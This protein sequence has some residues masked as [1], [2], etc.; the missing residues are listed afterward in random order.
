MH[1]LTR[2]L[3]STSS[4]QH[5]LLR[6][7]WGCFGVGPSIRQSQE[8][9]W[10]WESCSRSA[11][12]M[13]LLCRQVWKQCPR[14]WCLVHL[15][16]QPPGRCYRGWAPKS[17]KFL[18]A[19]EDQ[20]LHQKELLLPRT[21]SKL[22]CPSLQEKEANSTRVPAPGSSQTSPAHLV[23]QATHRRRWQGPWWGW[24]HQCA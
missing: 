17:R 9:R 24:R 14:Q 19:D 8:H 10:I 2:H 1:S 7:N 22:C 3:S 6:P 21:G 15:P 12:S 20:G 16:L 13:D 23:S 4:S 11:W 18:Q 5:L